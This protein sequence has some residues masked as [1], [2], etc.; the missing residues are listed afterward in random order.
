MKIVKINPTHNLRFMCGINS[1]EE[2]RDTIEKFCAENNIKTA[3][4]NALGSCKELELAFYNLKTKEYET[5]TFLKDLEIASIAGNVVTKDSKPFIHIHGTF[6][7]SSM[8]VVGGHINK[9]VI[10]ATCEVSIWPSEEFMTRKY[11]KLTGL[12]LLRKL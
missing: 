10:S 6:S 3:W 4:I 5:K 2:L 7:D 11:D 1:G 8:T 9:C 12:H